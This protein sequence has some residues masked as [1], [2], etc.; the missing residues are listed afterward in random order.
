MGTYSVDASVH[1]I[2]SS[3]ARCRLWIVQADDPTRTTFAVRK[4]APPNQYETL[5]DL[6]ISQM[7]DERLDYILYLRTCNTI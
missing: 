4:T 2:A 1:P 5:T 6:F 7:M 3:A